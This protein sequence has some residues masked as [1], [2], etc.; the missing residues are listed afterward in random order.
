MPHHILKNCLLPVITIAGM[1]L[2]GLVTGSFIV[3]SV[4]GWPGMGTL[5]VKALNSRD[6]PMIMGCTMLSCVLVIIG[7]LIADILYGVADPRLNE[8]RRNIVILEE[9]IQEEIEKADAFLSVHQH[10]A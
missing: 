6:Y 9:I 2:A 3:E 7:N 8:R 1:H 10:I 5:G 4:F